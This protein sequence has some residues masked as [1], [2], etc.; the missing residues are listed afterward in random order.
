M[1]RCKSTVRNGKIDM[2]PIKIYAIPVKANSGSSR[3]PASGLPLL[4]SPWA[5]RCVVVKRARL[6][7]QIVVPSE[8]LPSPQ[9]SHDPL[10]SSLPS[11][12]SPQ[13]SHDHE[14]YWYKAQVRL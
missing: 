5:A 6:K 1:C 11:A 7:Q 9:S 8:S 2:R 10:V 13:S 3:S 14:P 12:P 4:L